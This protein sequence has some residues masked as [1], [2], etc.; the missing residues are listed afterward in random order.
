[1]NFT[2]KILGTASA[3]PTVNRYPSA[4]VLDV[5]GRLFLIDCGEGAQMQMRRMGISYLKIEN[6]CISHI[7]GDHLFG[8]FG[9]LSTMSMLGRTAHLNIFA[10][11][12]F[13][14]VLKFYMSYFGEGTGFEIEHHVLSSKSPEVVWES[15][16]TEMLAFPL[17][18]RIEAFGFIIR[19][20]MPMFN[21]R[22]EAI[23]KYGLT[24]AEIAALKR[25]EDVVRPAG[26][27]SGPSFENGFRRFSGGPEPLVISMEEAA[28]IPYTPRSY[29]Y[30]SDTAPFPE[31][32]GWVRGVDLLY[33]EATYPA[34]MKELAVKT[35]HSTTEDA[36]RCALEA[37]AGRLVIGHYSSRF[38]DLTPFLEQTK[39]V[40]PKTFLAHE[41][42]KVEIPLKKSEL[43]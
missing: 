20:K 39:A 34:E 13:G 25:G 12:A 37:G 7:H 35:F 4:Q 23:Q 16:S 43:K 41:L 26:D 15:R 21:V 3:L 40:F 2:L 10:P 31:L 38:S 30:C 14:P 24:L 19:E 17:N 29:A 27:D 11:R 36:A 8:I 28:Y 33:H 1:M 18:H 5:R 32:S 9:L 22:K 6:I 42:D